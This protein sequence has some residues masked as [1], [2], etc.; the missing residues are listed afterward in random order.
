M[1]SCF[2]NIRRT[3]CAVSVLIVVSA[4]GA[5]TTSDTS[6][7]SESTELSEAPQSNSDFCKNAALA[8]TSMESVLSEE[9]SEKSPEESW[10]AVLSYA[11]KMLENA[12]DEIENEARR[13]QK[14][15]SD[16][17]AVLA[18]YDYDFVAMAANPDVV[19]EVEAIDKDGSMTK[20]SEAVDAYLENKC[21]I[22]QGS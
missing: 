21:G 22:P 7:E 6:S 19:T 16:Y 8:T 4:C 20:A 17:A 2:M 11:S 5:S 3:I 9:N 1:E 18:K 12:P 13:L 14:G 10:Q 15:I